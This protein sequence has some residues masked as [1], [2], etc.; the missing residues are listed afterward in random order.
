MAIIFEKKFLV[1][2]WAHPFFPLVIGE[3]SYVRCSGVIKRNRSSID[4]GFI[5]LYICIFV[6]LDSC[7]FNKYL[8][9]L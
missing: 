9:N 6:R 5:Y 2:I 8:V 7:K 1:D 3:I 4:P